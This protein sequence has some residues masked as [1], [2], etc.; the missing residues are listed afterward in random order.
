MVLLF[1]HV[2]NNQCR[3]L[4][5]CSSLVLGRFSLQTSLGN[6]LLCYLLLHVVSYSEHFT[7]VYYVENKNNEWWLTLCR[8]TVCPLSSS[9]T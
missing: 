4:Y 3:L 6:S 5:Q 1:V 9:S 2:Q 7:D 8:W